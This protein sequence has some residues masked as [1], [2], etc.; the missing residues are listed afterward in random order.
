MSLTSSDMVY[1]AE[2]PAACS[3]LQTVASGLQKL[4]T[5]E[6]LEGGEEAELNRF[7][8]LFGEVDWRSEHYKRHEHPELSVMAT[9]LRPLFYSK[10][11]ELE[12]PC[13][14]AYSERIYQTLKSA[15]RKIAVSPQ[16]LPQVQ[17][18]FQ[19]MSDEILSGLQYASMM[20]DDD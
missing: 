18:L 3:R 12:I 20:S 10:L 16:E 4:I 6:K 5:G 1:E 7:A 2:I 8:D 11:I 13:D 14:R 15:G 19:S 9:R 17:K